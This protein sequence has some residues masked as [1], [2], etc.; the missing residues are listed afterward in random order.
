MNRTDQELDYL[1]IIMDAPS[2]GPRSVY[3]FQLGRKDCIT[4]TAD[5]DTDLVLPI[6]MCTA[7]KEAK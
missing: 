2:G 6:H 5:L 3:A 1:Q 7:L 4:H